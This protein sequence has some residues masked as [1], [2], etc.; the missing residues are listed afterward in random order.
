MTSLYDNVM[1]MGD[2]NIDI[3]ITKDTSNYLPNLCDT[4]SL[5]NV[6]NGKTCFKKTTGTSNDIFLT[7]RPKS[8]YHTRISEAGISDPQKLILLFLAHIFQEYHQK[9]FKSI[10]FEEGHGQKEQRH[11]LKSFKEVLDKIESLKLK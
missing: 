2:L 1:V 6:I 7:N 5:E 4:F 9:W 10:V 11:V 8:I 3:D